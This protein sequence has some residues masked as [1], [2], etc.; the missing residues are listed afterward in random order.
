MD[1]YHF[2]FPCR[3]KGCRFVTETDS[4]TLINYRSKASQTCI[5]S[6][7]FFPHL[8]HTQHYGRAIMDW[9]RLPRTV[10]F[11]I[12]NYLFEFSPLYCKLNG[13]NISLRVYFRKP[14]IYNRDD[15]RQHLTDI[16]PLSPSLYT[17]HIM[18]FGVYCLRAQR[19][20]CSS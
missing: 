11:C 8:T 14:N 5:C 10:T 19:G 20:I 7:L 18:C 17:K 16:L 3:F 9:A 6:I 2:N 15:S 4:D 12:I 13:F 1:Y